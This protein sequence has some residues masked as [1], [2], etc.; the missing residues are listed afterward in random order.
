VTEFNTLGWFGPLCPLPVPAAGPFSPPNVLNNMRMYN[1]L[2]GQRIDE[3]PLDIAMKIFWEAEA[4]SIDGFITAEYTTPQGNRAVATLSGGTSVQ[5]G[6]VNPVGPF[7]FTPYRPPIAT[8]KEMLCTIQ[9]LGNFGL[10]TFHST[11]SSVSPRMSIEIVRRDYGDGQI[12]YAPFS[13]NFEGSLSPSQG[14]QIFSRPWTNAGRVPVGAANW[15]TPWGNTTTPLFFSALFGSETH[16]ASALTITVTGAD[17]AVR[18][19]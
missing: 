13:M 4:I 17:P 15:I 2:N 19:S 10:H 6:E 5:W 14:V 16:I 9:K 8:A 11:L 7:P 3:F 12:S 18:Y 1:I